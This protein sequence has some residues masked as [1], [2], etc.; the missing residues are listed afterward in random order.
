MQPFEHSR[1]QSKSLSG[2]ITIVE[3]HWR[4]MVSSTA[5]CDVKVGLPA[6]AVCAKSSKKSEAFSGG[7][8]LIVDSSLPVISLLHA[9][10][11]RTPFT[12]M[13]SIY[14]MMKTKRSNAFRLNSHRPRAARML[15]RPHRL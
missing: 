8:V 6:F 7:I 11:N 2:M 12:S 9:S 15:G 3:S 10:Q 14:Q 1:I 5:P 13:R 4:Q